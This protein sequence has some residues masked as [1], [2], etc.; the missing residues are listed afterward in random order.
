[1]RDAFG[2]FSGRKIRSPVRF[3]RGQH[4]SKRGAGQLDEKGVTDVRGRVPRVGRQLECRLDYVLHA[5]EFLPGREQGHKSAFELR[6]ALLP[7]RVALDLR[8][9]GKFRC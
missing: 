9:G 3:K 7:E 1:M 5:D 6:N 4:S 8:G 2:Q